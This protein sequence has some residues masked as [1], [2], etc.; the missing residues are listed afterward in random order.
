MAKIDVSN[1]TLLDTLTHPLK[2]YR[3]RKLIFN[4]LNYIIIPKLNLSHIFFIYLPYAKKL[5]KGI[6]K[7]S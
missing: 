3:F 2:K 7:V 5:Q 4:C 1:H 6:Q